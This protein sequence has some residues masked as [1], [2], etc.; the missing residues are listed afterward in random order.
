MRRVC[1]RLYGQSPQALRRRSRA[2]DW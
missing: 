2:Q 1:L